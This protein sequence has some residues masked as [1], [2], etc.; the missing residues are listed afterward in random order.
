MSLSY[1]LK[2]VT[3]LFIQY[4]FKIIGGSIYN[5]IE[6]IMI[7]IWCRMNPKKEKWKKSEE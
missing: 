5:T 6:W 7:I 2:E 1:T 4:N 3:S